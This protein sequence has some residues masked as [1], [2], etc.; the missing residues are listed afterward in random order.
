MWFPKLSP[1]APDANEALTFEKPGI[2]STPLSVTLLLSL[3]ESEAL[4]G[5]HGIPF[6]ASKP[7]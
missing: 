5:N 2:A 7:I 4:A 6:N 3:I 1:V